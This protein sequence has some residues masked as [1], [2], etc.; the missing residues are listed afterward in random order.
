M[1]IENYYTEE[2]C[3]KT[4]R[5]YLLDV[6]ILEKDGFNGEWFELMKNSEYSLQC[7]TFGHFMGG[8]D[9][10]DKERNKIQMAYFKLRSLL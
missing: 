4:S 5:L 8:K 1:N 7:S 2:N 6:P 3:E 10:E 9:N